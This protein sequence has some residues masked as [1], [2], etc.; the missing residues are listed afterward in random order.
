MLCEKKY[1]KKKIVPWFL[2]NRLIGSHYVAG[3]SIFVIGKKKKDA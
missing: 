1:T 3:H 2:L